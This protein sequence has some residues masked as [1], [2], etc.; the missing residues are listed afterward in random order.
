MKCGSM[1]EKGGK[2]VQRV[3][4]IDYS[5]LLEHGEKDGWG[6]GWEKK[7]KDGLGQRDNFFGTVRTGGGDE[8]FDE[9]GLRT[10]LIC[11]PEWRRFIFVHQSCRFS[12]FVDQRVLKY[13]EYL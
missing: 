4:E 11:L 13:Q 5:G 10:R 6:G 3:F 12:P 1:G 7:S 9:M 8:T 2:S